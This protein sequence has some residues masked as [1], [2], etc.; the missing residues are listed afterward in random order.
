[1]NLKKVVAEW[2]EYKGYDGLYNP[3][4]ECACLRNDLAPCGFP[5]WTE[6]ECTPGW[7]YEAT[8]AY[9][10]AGCDFIVTDNPPETERINIENVHH[11]ELSRQE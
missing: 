7:A 1:M 5:D 6:E 10:H 8:R 11:G 9:E 3:D 4:G 2:L